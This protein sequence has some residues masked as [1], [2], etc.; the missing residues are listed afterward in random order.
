MDVWQTVLDQPRVGIDDNYFS[1]GGDSIKAIQIVSRLLRQNL[2][3]ELRDLFR[4]PDDS[5]PRA[6]CGGARSPRS[7]R[8]HEAALTTAPLMPAQARFFAEHTVEPGRFQHAVLLDAETRLDPAVVAR[9]FATLRDRHDSLRLTFRSGGASAAEQTAAAPGGPPPDVARVRS[10]RPRRCMVRAAGLTPTRFRRASI[11]QP[12]RCSAWPSSARTQGDRL[13][14]VVHH[15][16]IDV[17]S[18]RVLIEELEAIVRGADAAAAH[19]FL[20]SAVRSR[21]RRA[22]DS[23][24]VTASV[25]TGTRST[26]GCFDRSISATDARQISRSGTRRS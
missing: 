16:A 17:V 22:A 4:Y 12:V 6:A 11:C 3:V 18:W 7:A 2:R 26:R 24:E 5:E 13:L 21:S 19:R 9:A 20:F 8:E 1:L 23:D 25:S 15:L 14:I 10:P